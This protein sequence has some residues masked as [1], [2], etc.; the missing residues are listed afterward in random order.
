[1]GEV[2]GLVEPHRVV[3]VEPGDLVEGGVGVTERPVEV[4]RVDPPLQ[5]G[6]ARAGVGAAHRAYAVRYGGRGPRDIVLERR[7]SG[8]AEQVWR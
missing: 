4:D 1:V 8:P 7:H 5:V 6:Q 3:E 2:A